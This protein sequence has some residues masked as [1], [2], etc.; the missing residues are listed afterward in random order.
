MSRL[1]NSGELNRRIKIRLWSNAANAAFGLDQNV[2]AG[3][4]RWAKVEPVHGLAIKAGMQTGEV[5][6]HLFW[7]RY[8]AGTTPEEI[9]VSHVVEWNGRRYRVLDAI[10]VEDAQRFTRITAKDLGAIA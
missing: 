3:L 1:P 7:V 9:T 2:D 5:P 6:T 10:N 8:Y 4:D